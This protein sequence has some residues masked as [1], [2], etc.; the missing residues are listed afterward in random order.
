MNS[1]KFSCTAVIKNLGIITF[2]LPYR[3]DEMEFIILGWCAN[4]EKNVYRSGWNVESHLY[5]SFQ[6]WKLRCISKDKYQSS[7]W[8]E[9]C[10]FFVEDYGRVIEPI[11]GSVL[12]SKS[13]E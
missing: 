6:E 10:K 7:H 1:E 9:V 5:K 2:N 11:G 13:T 12:S 4:I 3:D 8:N